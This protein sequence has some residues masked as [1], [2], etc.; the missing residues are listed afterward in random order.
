MPTMGEWTP[1]L[2]L[3]FFTIDAAPRLKR[4]PII[5]VPTT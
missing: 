4:L 3:R 1:T 2:Y 5:S